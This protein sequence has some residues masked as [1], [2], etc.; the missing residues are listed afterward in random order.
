ML[1][2]KIA[3]RFLTHGRTQS[4]LI[5]VGIA[6]AISIQIFVGLLI[7]SL[8]RTLVDRTIGNLAGLLDEGQEV[9]NEWLEAISLSVEEVGTGLQTLHG[10]LTQLESSLAQNHQELHAAI[11]VVRDRCERP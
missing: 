7:D 2:F 10:R 3:V 11:R 4:I 1:A 9:H 8:Q 5:L 6:I